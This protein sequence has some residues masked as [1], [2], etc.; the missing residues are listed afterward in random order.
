MNSKMWL[1]LV[2]A[3]VV[4]LN[5]RSIGGASGRKSNK[6]AKAAPAAVAAKADDIVDGY[7]KTPELARESALKNS[8][9][10][11]EDLLTQRLRGTGWSATDEQLETDFLVRHN[12]I[13]PHG[14]P[15]PAPVNVDGK[16]S[17][18]ARCRV[19]L[20]HDYLKK[21]ETAAREQTVQ[22]RHSILA[23]VLGGILAVALVTAAYL[24]LEEST[25]GY[26]TKLLRL[27]AVVVLAVVGA[28]LY[29]T[30]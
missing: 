26:A 12:V 1:A 8:R 5:L 19:E 27:V 13:Q 30:R 2:V 24:R 20:T 17:L 10:R 15:E 4:V 3:V 29:L 16:P 23:R 21:I 14:E 9:L 11:V 28:G 18:V 25:R 6:P 7:G 22:E